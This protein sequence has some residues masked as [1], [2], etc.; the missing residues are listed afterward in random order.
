MTGQHRAVD[1]HNFFP[2]E[3]EGVEENLMVRHTL[4]RLLL[5]YSN[6]LESGESILTVSICCKEFRFTECL[7]K[8]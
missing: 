4:P 1:D 8:T 5:S 7:H 3:E 2:R 6:I